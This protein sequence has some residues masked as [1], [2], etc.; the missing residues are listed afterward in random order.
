MRA[1]PARER[2]GDADRQ[3]R[4][5]CA[6]CRRDDEAFDERLAHEPRSR[7]P[8]GHAQRE[9]AAPLGRARQHEIGD[10][11]AADEQ[12]QQRAGHEQ[13]RRRGNGAMQVLDERLGLE[14]VA[15]MGGGPRRRHPRGHAIE[16]ALHISERRVR[17]QAPDAPVDL[18]HV[19]QR[20]LSQ[21]LPSGDK[22]QVDVGLRLFDLAEIGEA[23]LEHADHTVW[24]AVEHDGPAD[25]ARVGAELS[26]PQAVIENHDRRGTGHLVCR[27]EQPAGR[28][29]RA[30]ERQIA[31]RAERRRQPYRMIGRAERDRA[32]A[33]VR[34]HVIEG[35]DLV[36]NR[37]EV[38]IR[39]VAGAPR[40]RRPHVHESRSV[41]IGQRGPDHAARGREHRGA[42]AKT[43]SE[44]Q[45][46]RDGQS[47][48]ADEQ[49]KGQPRVLEHAAR[50]RRARP[51]PVVRTASPTVPVDGNAE[52]QHSS[53]GHDAR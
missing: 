21:E 16:L 28:R 37:L 52:A 4:A 8:D 5:D 11:R 2:G 24:C 43:E 48:P 17:A 30:E 51:G 13:A 42:G 19:G 31:N 9:L 44:R 18:Q 1:D 25:H 33:L 22:R 47:R 7:C 32:P 39:E 12:H 29:R 50:P 14:R 45:D 3:K 38:R 27:F 41:R 35:R 10:V 36:A 26:D 40:P 20:R 15:G 6:T 34:R 46:C 53:R 23:R 49:A